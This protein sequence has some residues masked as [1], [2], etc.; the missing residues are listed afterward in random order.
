MNYRL[1]VDGKYKKSAYTEYI[2]KT[3]LKAPDFAVKQST[4]PNENL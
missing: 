1:K 3:K 2:Q 4:L